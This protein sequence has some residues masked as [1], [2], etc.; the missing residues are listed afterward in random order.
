MKS[1]VIRFVANLYSREH[2]AQFA[3]Y[4]VLIVF[5]VIAAAVGVTAFGT[6]LSAFFSGLMARIGI[7]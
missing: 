1:R 2:G 4:G 6:Q 3:E 5:G 7:S